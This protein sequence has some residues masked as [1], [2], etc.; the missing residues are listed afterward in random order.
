MSFPPICGI[1]LYLHIS[2]IIL[3]KYSGAGNKLIVS[4]YPIDV[5]IP[6]GSSRL[7]FEVK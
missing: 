4:P 6:T 3:L 7:T 5:N 1:L 2:K